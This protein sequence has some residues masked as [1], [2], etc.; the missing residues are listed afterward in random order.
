MARKPS[1][2]RRPLPQGPAF[3]RTK[4]LLRDLRLNTVCD[5]ANCPNRLECYDKGVAAFLILGRVCT[6]DCAFCDIPPGR[7]EPVDGQ[8]PD[9]LAQAAAR[10]KLGH[11]VV[12]SVSRDDLPDGG[13]GHFA[14]V[15]RAL[16]RDLPGAT[17][18]VL[19]PD[20]GGDP[21][22]LGTVQGARPDVL[23]HNLETV[24]A[25]YE[26]IRPQAVY[27]RSLDLLARAKQAVPTGLTKSGIMLGLGETPDQ[28][29]GV[30][31]DL[32]AV[33]CDIVTMGQYLAPSARHA[34]VVRY[35]PPEEF[36]AWA[37]YGLSL[38][39]P[40]M[41]CAPLVRSSYNAGRFV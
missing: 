3:S 41:H 6:R 35:A 19:I 39:I 37:A 25:L 27:A 21:N 7:P 38:G 40:A 17:L 24:P 23:N 22:S 10:L 28:I 33:R 5:G 29:R 20:F 30:L 11:V 13:A 1:W 12:T 8:E 32:A 4:G 14:A 26:A 31:A 16:R 15:L 9:R 36:D 34:P 2:L 18:E